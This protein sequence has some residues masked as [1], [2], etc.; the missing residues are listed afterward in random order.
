MPSLARLN[1]L[2]NGAPKTHAELVSDAR[3]EYLCVAEE[4]AYDA[5]EGADLTPQN[6]RWVALTTRE[7]MWERYCRGH[8]FYEDDNEQRE[9]S[10]AVVKEAL[11]DMLPPRIF[12]VIRN[13]E[14][15]PYVDE[16]DD[17]SEDEECIECEEVT[18]PD[19]TTL[20]KDANGIYY[21]PDSQEEVEVDDKY[22][23]LS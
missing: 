11:Q 5:F 9:W 1:E 8:E 16:S 17:D 23:Q 4:I 15:I 19:G 6:L 3:G 13:L 10:W 14:D 21:D 12:Q 18:F 7:N 2:A 20:F 22:G